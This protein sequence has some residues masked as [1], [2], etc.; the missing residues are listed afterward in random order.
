MKIYESDYMIA[1]AKAHED[2]KAYQ[3]VESFI[4]NHFAMIEHMKKT[5]LYDVYEYENKL[6][7]PMEILT[8]DNEKLKKEVNDLRKQLGLGKKYKD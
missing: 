6:A 1:L 3:M 5:S 7:Q 8:Y 4:K 2:E